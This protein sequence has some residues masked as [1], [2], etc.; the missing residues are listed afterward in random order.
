M[1]TSEFSRDLVL[2]DVQLEPVHVRE[3]I[4]DMV[5][6]AY[7]LQMRAGD[8]FPPVVVFD[9]GGDVIYLADGGHRLAAARK[10]GSA[11]FPA[12][13]HVGTKLDA[14]WFALGANKSHGLMTTD[15]DKRLGI[16]TLSATWPEKTQREIAEHIGCSQQFVSQVLLTATGKVLH[17]E[18]P[19]GKLSVEKATAIEEAVRAGQSDREIIRTLKTSCH[20]VARVRAAV[21]TPV[22]RVDKSKARIAERRKVMEDMAEKGYTSRQIADAVGMTFESARNT[23]RNNGIDV[24]ADRAVG[25]TKRLN[26]NRITHTIV[27]DA[28]NLTAGVELIDFTELD[29]SRIP[30]WLGSLQASREKLGGLIRRLMK[31]QQHEVA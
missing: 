24:P 3:Q 20:T 5:V 4:N 29:R 11:T 17:S 6:A 30:E 9:D 12:E 2:A 7:A 1:T 26:A 23:L 19:F 31:E 10:N 22:V 8:V 13:V 28:A 27:M 21:G 15:A 18:Q 25:K 16:Q 14:M